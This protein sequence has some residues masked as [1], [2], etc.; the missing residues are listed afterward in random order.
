MNIKGVTALK[1]IVSVM[2]IAMLTISL[3]AC[4]SS[5]TESPSNNSATSGPAATPATAA[6]AATPAATAQKEPMVLGASL[7]L[8]GGFGFAGSAMKETME[9]LTEQVN[10]SGGINGQPLKIIYYDDENNPEFAV[11]N[12]N[13][14][15]KNDKVKII[16]GPSVGATSK[17]VQPMADQEKVIMYSMSGAY[18][19]PTSSY[20]FSSSYGQDA[21]HKIIHEWLIEKGIKSAAM[22]ATNDVSG[23]I[24]VQEVGKLQGKDGIKYHIERMGINDVDITPQLTKI[25]N[26]GIGALVVIGP[27]KAAGVA[28]Q[29]AVKLKMDIPIIATHSQLSDVFAQSIKDFI[30]NKML[31]TGPPVMAFNELSDTNIFKAKLQTFTNDFKKK[32]NKNPDYLGSIAYDTLSIVVEGLKKVGNDADKMKNYLEGVKDFKGVHAVFNL[33]KED[34]RGTTS[35]GVVLLRLDKDLSWHIEW[36]PKL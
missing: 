7:A 35:K 25:R 9:L 11:R 15:I 14:L 10:A 23:D 33:T 30:P 1:K 2:V 17:A 21:M 20:A 12:A 6:T 24:S 26:E 13:K 3:A 32:Y 5:K 8:T 28:I 27:G 34:H 18:N 4:G 19:A 16:L 29:N 22:I 31:V 36:E